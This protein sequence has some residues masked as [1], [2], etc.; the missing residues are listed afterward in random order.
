M[1]RVLLADDHAMVREALRR[2]IESSGDFCIVAEAG[3]GIEAV[4]L[5]KEHAPDVAVLDLW[6]PLLSG[7]EATRAIV[8]SD[9]GTRVLVLSMHEADTH[10]RSAL[11]AGASGYVVKSAVSRE[12]IEALTAVFAG[13]AYVSPA[14]ARHVVDAASGRD[15]SR[16]PLGLLTARE[17]EV[18][19]ML[20]DGL[21]SKEIAA[22]L[23][24]STKT[25]ESHRASV[26]RKLDVHKVSSLVRVAV[27]EGLVAL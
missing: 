6:M 4:A 14:V 18:L 24:V 10:V 17:R 23:G 8:A 2:V 26:M 12:L 20:A 13:Q 5:A 7:Q 11:E 21:S 19:S 3:D 15:G 27:R 16:G 22:R 1:I 9:C 25:T